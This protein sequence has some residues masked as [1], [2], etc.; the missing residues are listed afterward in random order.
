M[1]T[2][3]KFLHYMYGANGKGGIQSEVEIYGM[4]CT[5]EG[6]MEATIAYLRKGVYKKQLLEIEQKYDLNK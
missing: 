4:I 6:K 1:K 3:S 2:S 5:L